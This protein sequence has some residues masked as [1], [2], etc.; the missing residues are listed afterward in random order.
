ME[1]E[2]NLRND[3]YILTY[4]TRLILTEQYLYLRNKT[5]TYGTILTYLRNNTYTQSIEDELRSHGGGDEQMNQ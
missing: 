2:M 1:E 5:Y 4:G 3:T